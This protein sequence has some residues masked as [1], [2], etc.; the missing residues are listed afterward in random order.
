MILCYP[1]FPEDTSSFLRR[2]QAAPSAKTEIIGGIR[3]MS[4]QTTDSF[5]VLMYEDAYLKNGIGHVI[6]YQ[7]G[8][9][10]K[11]FLDQL[12]LHAEGGGCG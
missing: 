9:A 12:S 11:P 8:M 10:P 7:Y 4:P 1:A 6:F 2:N 5:Q 3:L